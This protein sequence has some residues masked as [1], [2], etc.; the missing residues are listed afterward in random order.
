M[1]HG[2]PESLKIEA[3]QKEVQLGGNAPNESYYWHLHWS[4]VN[5]LEQAGRFEEAEA[6]LDNMKQEMENQ[7]VTNPDYQQIA[8]RAQLEL[9]EARQQHQQSQAQR[10][11]QQEQKTKSESDL[12]SI[13]IWSVT[14]FAL[15]S[16]L[17][18]TVYELVIKKK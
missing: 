17:G 9:A 7:G 18:V 14:L 5:S 4:L 13:I 3:I 2:L 15:F 10:T 12:K 16:I 1:K 8:R 6:A 11:A